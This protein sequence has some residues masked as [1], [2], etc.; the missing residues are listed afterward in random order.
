MVIVFFATFIVYDRAFLEGL[1]I[2][3]Y[4]LILVLS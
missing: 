1:D 4:N 3:N 2:G